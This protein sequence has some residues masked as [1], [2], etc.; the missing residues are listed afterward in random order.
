MSPVEREFER[1]SLVYR[2]SGIYSHPQQNSENSAGLP[3]RYE[4]FH[5]FQGPFTTMLERDVWDGKG[6]NKLPAPPMRMTQVPHLEALSHY[7]DDHQPAGNKNE[8]GDRNKIA[9]YLGIHRQ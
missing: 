5:G 7:D 3:K 4:D 1:I 8:V 9:G 2:Q 6:S